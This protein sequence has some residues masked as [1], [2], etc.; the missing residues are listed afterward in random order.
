MQRSATLLT[1]G[2]TGSHSEMAKHSPSK[3]RESSNVTRIKGGVAR[4]HT[5]ACVKC[6]QHA[7]GR[8]LSLAAP[9]LNRQQIKQMLNVLSLSNEANQ[10]QWLHFNQ[11]P[12]ST[13]QQHPALMPGVT[14]SGCT[15]P[16]AG[17]N[18]TGNV[19][20]SDTGTAAAARRNCNCTLNATHSHGSVVLNWAAYIIADVS[21]V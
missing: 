6:K 12:W 21:K 8:S 13:L 9:S 20:A 5:T 15:Q 17:E 16:H 19:T 4:F 18:T 7:V 11:Q 1:T 14:C 3:E 10:V 2:T